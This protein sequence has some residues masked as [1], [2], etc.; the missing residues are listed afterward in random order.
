M[1]NAQS[2]P[3]TPPTP[4]PL[5]PLSAEE[6]S[7]AVAIVRR[8]GGLDNTAWVETVATAEP[9]KSEL[10]NPRSTWRKAQVCFYERSSGRTFDGTVDL[11]NE[12]LET[13]AHVLDAHARIVIDEFNDGRSYRHLLERVPI[14]LNE[15]QTLGIRGAAIHAWME[16]AGA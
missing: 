10:K 13:W 2:R 14:Y 5:D 16:L 4:H 1:L 15:D 3:T 7:R 6:I 9:E 11:A 12:T 8:D